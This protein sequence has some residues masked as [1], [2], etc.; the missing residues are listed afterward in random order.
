MKECNQCKV[1]MFDGA[2]GCGV[3]GSNDVTL[4]TPIRKPDEF[5]TNEELI[6]NY[7]KQLTDPEMTDLGNMV[8]VK[9]TTNVYKGAEFDR[10][11]KK[12]KQRKRELSKIRQW[13]CYNDYMKKSLE[14]G[15]CHDCDYG[16]KIR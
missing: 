12:R 11:L 5:P 10:E 14:H 8:K 4:L 15:V 16:E 13:K 7:N 3:C 1:K 6:G 2:K 9:G